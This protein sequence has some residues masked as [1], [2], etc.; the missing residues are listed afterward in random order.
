MTELHKRLRE[1]P[2]AGRVILYA[3]APQNEI[4]DEVFQFLEDNGYRNIAM[5]VEGFQGWVK[6]KYPV[7]TGRR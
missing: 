7:E 3:A 5:M 1:I 2:Q 4:T 6:R